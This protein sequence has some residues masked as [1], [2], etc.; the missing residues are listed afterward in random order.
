MGGMLAT[1]FHS[2]C[3]PITNSDAVEIYVYTWFPYQ[4]SRPRPGEGTH[5]PSMEDANGVM[6]SPYESMGENPRQEE[7]E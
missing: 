3:Y 1:G 6:N 4:R 2:L 7:G 5:T